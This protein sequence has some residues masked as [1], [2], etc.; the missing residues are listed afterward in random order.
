SYTDHS[1]STRTLKSL[2]SLQKCPVTASLFL[3]ID[4]PRQ[5]E[6]QKATATAVSG[7]VAKIVASRSRLIFAYQ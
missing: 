2:K 7:V 1:S 6:L 3:T 5:A 4:I